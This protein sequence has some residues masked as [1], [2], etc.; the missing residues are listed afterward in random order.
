MP[1]AD[2]SL[3]CSN[4]P[5]Y[6]SLLLQKSALEL[7]EEGT[8]MSEVTIAEIPAGAAG[9]VTEE[10]EF[11]ATRPFVYVV[12]EASSGAVLFVGVFRGN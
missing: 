9:P 6:V 8:Q 7:S 11:H 5:L 1:E 2:F 12:Q 4:A 10:R 3:M